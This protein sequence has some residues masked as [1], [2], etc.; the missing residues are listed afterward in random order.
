MPHVLTLD[1]ADEAATA[2]LAAT[3]GRLLTTGDVVALSGDLGAG[4]S[5]FARHLI[6][7]LGDADEEVPS[8]TFTLVQTYDL[9]GFPLWHFDLYRLTAPDEVLE[10]GWEEVRHEGVALVEWPARLGALLPADRLDL[11]LAITGPESRRATLT[12]HG[13]WTARLATAWEG[14][15]P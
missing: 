2:R 3:L 11:D 1:L 10:L 9:P 5:A 8:P 4:K 13:A 14:F 15:K 7:S 12:G 6:R